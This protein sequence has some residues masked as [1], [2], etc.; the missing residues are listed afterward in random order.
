M[1]ARA[2][3][4]TLTVLALLTGSFRAGAEEGLAVSDAWVRLAPPS[5]PS[6]AG[7]LSLANSGPVTR[8][9]VAV[10]SPGYAKV[11]L[12]QSRIDG[13]VASMAPVDR[14]ELAPGQV[15][16]FAPGGLHLMLIGPKV[17][18]ALG[19]TVELTLRLGDGTTVAARAVVKR[20][21]AAANPD[22]GS[23]P[24]RH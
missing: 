16:H 6:H 1:Q 5:A 15:V 23:A 19:S 20:D 13:D 12:H 14:I 21:A 17:P 24:H 9:L 11:E 10:E 2:I 3:G 7:Y 22:H 8:S 18:V 4:A